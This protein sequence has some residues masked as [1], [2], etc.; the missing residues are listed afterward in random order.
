LTSPAP[1]HS[2]NLLGALSLAVT[3]RTNEAFAE[4]GELTETAAAALTAL[5]QFLDGPGVEQLAQVVGL[6]SSGAVRLVGRLQDAG[7]VKREAGRDAR[8]SRVRLTAAGRRAARR[9][10]AARAAVLEGALRDL[11]GEEVALLDG[12]LSRALVRMM[13]G[14]GA[15]RWMCRMCDM[16]ACG[17]DEG[18]CPVA[19]EARARW[20]AGR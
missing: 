7:Y 11:S 14:P 13:R 9:V 6:T 1:E 17:R 20:G 16:A 8:V 10:A 18:H 3:D 19:N 5:D 12:L 2:A 4:K 15:T